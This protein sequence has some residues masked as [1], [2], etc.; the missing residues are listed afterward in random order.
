[1]ASTRKATGSSEMTNFD[2]DRWLT[3]HEGIK[4]CPN[5]IKE[6][7][8]NL[9]LVSI[10]AAHI[11]V[12]RWKTTYRKVLLGLSKDIFHLD[13]SLT[14]LL[15]Y[16]RFSFLCWAQSASASLLP[17]Q[18]QSEMTLPLTWLPLSIS[19]HTTPDTHRPS[20]L[21]PVL[22]QTWWITCPLL[23]LIKG[24]RGDGHAPGAWH[25]TH[26]S[27]CTQSLITAV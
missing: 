16:S 14:G 11:F 24:E 23:P 12:F 6:R 21:H 4:S 15:P 27:S 26:L 17:A 10:S 18:S 3:R 13:S 2:D 5:N 1:M 8:P 20:Q 19:S 25:W 22:W 7:R 9:C